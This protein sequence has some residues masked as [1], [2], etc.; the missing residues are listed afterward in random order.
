[1]AFTHAKLALA[2]GLAL[3]I[4][5][6]VWAEP[7][8]L[9][10][11]VMLTQSGIGDEAVIAKIK[12]TATHYDLS[13]DQMLDLKRKG[14][15]GPI[16]AALMT[17]GAD[18]APKY[19]TDSADP[20]VLH[21]AGVYL[22]DQ[23]ANKAV[24]IDPTVTNQAK[25]GGILGYAFTGG[26]ASASIKASIQNA[27]ARVRATKATPQFL[28]FF[29]ESNAQAANGVQTWASGTA[30]TVTSPSEFSLVRLSQKDNRR[31][32]RVGSFNIAGAKTGVM[33]KD[34]IPFN[35]ELVRPGVYRV[36]PGTALTAGEYG[37]MYSL[38]G[39]GAGGAMTARIFDFGV[40]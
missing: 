33:D 12:N 8:T 9:D 21:P 13:V 3:A 39:G 20:A 32:A 16:I 14:V 28:F 4:S 29:D 5:G 10:S 1:M 38:S 30:A 23:T 7:M 18:A 25:T 15:S 6:P 24:R 22:I 36:T 27:A 2:A 19:S 34:R 40:Q 31:E 35:Y 26:L 37:F 17:T 11:V